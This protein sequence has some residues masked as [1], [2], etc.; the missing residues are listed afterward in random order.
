[1]HGAAITDPYRRSLLTST[2]YI[3]ALSVTNLVPTGAA[4]V[5]LEKLL[6]YYISLSAAGIFQ[7]TG[8]MRLTIQCRGN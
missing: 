7:R 4:Y 2:Q 1:M 8:K 5:G 3:A 6:N